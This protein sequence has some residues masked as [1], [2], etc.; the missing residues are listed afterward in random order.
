M[1]NTFITPEQ[2]ARSLLDII[3]TNAKIYGVSEVDLANA[4]G[5]SM[6]W[7][8]W[9]QR[10]IEPAASRPAPV[11]PDSATHL[12]RSAPNLPALLAAAS[13]AGSEPVAGPAAMH[14]DDLE[15]P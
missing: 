9:G 1:A 8:V 7:G 11:H 2:A 10:S 14:A 4:L 3:K 13:P 15:R 12:E 6:F 5:C